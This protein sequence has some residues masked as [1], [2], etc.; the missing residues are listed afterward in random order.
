MIKSLESEI[1]ARLAAKVAALPTQAYPDNPD[2]FSLMSKAGM[3]LVHYGGSTYGPLLSTDPVVQERRTS[4]NIVIVVRNLREHTGAYEVLDAVRAAI[5]G[6]KPSD[7]DKAIPVKEEYINETSGIW[8]YGITI[9]I[10]TISV[11]EK[12]AEVLPVLKHLTMVDTFD[13]TEIYAPEEPD[14]PDEEPTEPEGE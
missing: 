12:E 1:V 9:E 13:T 3:I 8:Q 2:T 10:P 4:W 5:I 11:E 6:W 14:K 7:G